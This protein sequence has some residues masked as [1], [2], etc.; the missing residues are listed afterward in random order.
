MACPPTDARLP[1]QAQA[2]A[3]AW[4]SGARGVRVFGACAFSTGPGSA[5]AAV[6]LLL[7]LPLQVAAAQGCLPVMY[8][9]TTM[10]PCTA[11]PN[12][13]TC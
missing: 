7:P 11:V 13:N 10:V 5:A 2:S 6:T 4:S 9:S 12:K 8:C 3:C 1:S